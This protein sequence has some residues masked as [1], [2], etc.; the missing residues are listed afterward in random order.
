MP[1]ICKHA[2]ITKDNINLLIEE[3]GFK[4]DIDFLSLDIDGIDYYIWKSLEII[5]PRV[6]ICECHNIIPDDM[7]VTIPYKDDFS[8]ISKDNYNEEFMGVSPLA[9]IKL[10][11]EKGYRL[12]GSHKY[13]F[14]LIFMRNDTGNEYFP[15]VGLYEITNNQYTIK[16]KETRWPKV[17]DA[18]W[19]NV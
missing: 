6:F 1:P 19:I 16:A 14:N 9:M 2:W 11:K 18:P 4:G 7:A 12:I 8:H 13:G 3:E 5:S 10:S 17:K 15:E